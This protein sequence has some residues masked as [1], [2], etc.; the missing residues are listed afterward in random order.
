MRAQ[1]GRGKLTR[2]SSWDLSTPSRRNKGWMVCSS[3]TDYFDTLQ[4][5]G[6]K[7]AEVS[8]LSPTSAPPASAPIEPRSAKRSEPSGFPVRETESGVNTVV[9]AHNFDA[10]HCCQGQRGPAH[11]PHQPED[12]GHQSIVIVS[13]RQSQ[14][15]RE[16]SRLPQEGNPQKHLASPLAREAGPRP[17]RQ[18]TT[19]QLTLQIP[20]LGLWL[21]HCH[22]LSGSRTRC[23]GCSTDCPHMDNEAR[24]SR[25]WARLD[26][27][28]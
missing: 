13:A 6:P 2:P 15:E 3:F 1:R 12:T 28:P 11:C 5:E 10:L 16:R 19:T 24:P 18:A 23:A 7:G 27:L 26:A 14:H 25:A 20:G 17:T 9:A 4:S 8:N 21:R 22:W